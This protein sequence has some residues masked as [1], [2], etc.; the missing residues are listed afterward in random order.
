MSVK[1][2]KCGV[3]AES[4]DETL[5][6]EFLD[7]ELPESIKFVYK[8]EHSNNRFHGSLQTN[9]VN[10]VFFEEFF[11]KFR[12]K[13]TYLNS[14]NKYIIAKERFDQLSRLQGRALKFWFENIKQIVIVSELSFEIFN[15]NHIEGELHLK[16][17]DL[18]VAIKPTEVQK[19]AQQS[20]IFIQTDAS[21]NTPETKDEF[22]KS[23][24]GGNIGLDKN[25]VSPLDPNKLI[26]EL[27]QE[28]KDLL[29]AL[30][31][32]RSILK[33]ELSINDSFSKQ[34]IPNTQSDIKKKEQRLKQID[35]DLKALHKQ[36]GK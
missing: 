16:A 28:K 24:I 35:S 11:V 21:P 3:G 9:Q 10:G 1:L 7:R 36:I 33:K 20:F 32:D 29:Q 34:S 26:K 22:D 30:E 6:F 14:K 17:H 25:A 12:F 8:T 15:Y 19:I 13:G 4:G 2:T 23:K 31:T 5:L 18:Q 27:G